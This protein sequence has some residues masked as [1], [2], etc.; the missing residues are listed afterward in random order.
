MD[1]ANKVGANRKHCTVIFSG[2]TD[3]DVLGDSGEECVS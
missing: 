1:T 2:V 3:Y